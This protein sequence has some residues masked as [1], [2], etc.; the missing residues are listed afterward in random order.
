MASSCCTRSVLIACMTFAAPAPSSGGNECRA[1]N[2]AASNAQLPRGVA[3]SVTAMQSRA[4]AATGVD[5][6]GTS[7]VPGAPWPCRLSVGDELLA[8]VRLAWNGSRTFRD[9]C[10][11][12]ASA[13]AIVFVRPAPPNANYRAQATIGK[14]P[15]GV[16]VAHVRI[17]LQDDGP[18]L[19]GHELEHVLERAEGINL[20]LEAHVPASGVSSIR[21]ELETRRAVL[22]GRRVA[23]EVRKAAVSRPG[24]ADNAASGVRCGS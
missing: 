6:A 2:E 9:Q 17:R 3:G 24:P 8:S 5:N 20:R 10:A 19:I 11:K 22:A 18:E 15:R 4:P 16:L 12:L 1:A 14:S 13:G 21:G 7:S 23:R